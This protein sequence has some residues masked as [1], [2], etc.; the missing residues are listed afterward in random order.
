MSKRSSPS[1]PLVNGPTQVSRQTLDARSLDSEAYL[2][3]LLGDNLMFWKE[4]KDYVSLVDIICLCLTSKELL[5]RVE[6]YFELLKE[7]CEEQS[8]SD[9]CTCRLFSNFYDG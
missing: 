4:M 6:P 5:S 1:S 9:L 8:S 3:M 2:S 7:Q